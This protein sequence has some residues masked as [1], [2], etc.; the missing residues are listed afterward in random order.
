MT[1][2]LWDTLYVCDARII[3]NYVNLLHI[4]AHKHF[5]VLKTK[6]FLNLVSLTYYH[7]Y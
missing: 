7:T 2:K 3:E 6:R 1:L 5:A 4:L